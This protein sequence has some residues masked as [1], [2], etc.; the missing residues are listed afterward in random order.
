MKVLRT[1]CL[2]AA[3]AATGLASAPA[4]AQD[5]VLRL[6]RGAASQDVG[7]DVNRAVVLE[8]IQPFAEVS[9]ANPGI[10][11]VAALSN[12]SIYILGKRP[13]RTTLTLL[14][15][16]GRLIANVTVN[17]GPDLAELKE[18]FSEILPGE[19]IDVRTANDG[20]VL[21]G[22]VSSAPRLQRAL[23]LAGRYAPGRVTNMMT[24]GG[25]QQV[26]LKVRFA[27]VQRNASKRLGFNW[28][29]GISGPPGR[30][31][32]SYSS[33]GSSGDYI[34]NGNSAGG[35]TYTS[36]ANP[37]SLLTIGYAAGS[38]I[39]EL[40]IDALENKGLAR[41]LAEPNLVALSGDAADFLA[42]GEYPI[43][44]PDGDGGVAVE[45]R[46]FG[47][48]LGFTPTVLDDEL[49]NLQIS[50][51]SSAIDSSVVVETNGIRV[52]GFSVRRAKTTVELRD[53]QSFAIAGLL[54]DSF[55]DNASQIPW[56]GDIPVLGTLFRSTDFQSAQTEL[57]IIV[58]VHLVS[59]T[60]GDALGMPT[61]RIRAP[62]EAELF[63]LGRTEGSG[64]VFDVASQ[65][66]Q[67]AYGYVME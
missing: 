42:G 25:T 1:F 21:S 63:L 8:A 20:L 45:Y 28:A 59:P 17:V 41:T 9:V 53:G 61:D 47:I 7:V 11:D 37:Q 64:P 40:T 23:E 35:S 3:I 43:P 10:A 39:A 2:A 67:G 54:Q 24:V 46:P 22:A 12:T 14:G 56:V 16:G 62:S 6:A 18:R 55:R 4:W 65:E 5:G 48:S 57:V 38:F 58:T 19:K 36:T 44:V 29:F 13:G 49:I 15:E 51:E 50:A 32:S 66:F 34:G 60:S 30:G 52:E 26:M 33:V 31:D 27:E